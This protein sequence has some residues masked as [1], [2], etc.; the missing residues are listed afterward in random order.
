MVESMESSE[1]E[2]VERLLRSFGDEHA[3][4]LKTG[5]AQ[6]RRVWTEADGDQAAF[7]AFVREYFITDEKLLAETLQ[8][9]DR[10][11]EAISGHRVA[12]GRTLREPVDLSMGGL[13]P[14]DSMFFAFDPFDHAMED[15]FA[16][17]WAFVAL[18]NFEQLSVEQLEAAQRS[19]ETW[20]ASRLAS[21]FALRV[22][23]EV[24]RRATAAYAAAEEYIASYNIHLDQIWLAD[25]QVFPQGKALISHW[26]LRDELKAHYSSGAEAVE[27]Q[28]II[29]EIMLRII[30]QEIPAEVIDSAEHRWDPL[31][32]L[33]DGRASNGPEE[34]LRYAR[35]LDVFHAE[36][37]ID[38]YSPAFPSL[39]SRRFEYEREI[40]MEEQRAILE[41]VVSSPVAIEVGKLIEARLGRPLQP[42]D[43][44]YAGFKGGKGRFAEEELS[45]KT[46]AL[47]PD[48]AAFENA[49]P[50]IFS[51]MGFSETSIELLSSHIAVDAARGSGH[52]MGAGMRGDRA[53]L[54]TRVAADGMDY[55]GYNIAMHELGHNVE[56][57]FSLERLDWF[58]LSGVP[59][60][61]FTEAFAFVFQA[62]DLDVLGI[63]QPEASE[64]EREQAMEHLAM[65]W[66]TYEIA[67]VALL[68][69]AVW[70]YMYAHPEL[71][72]SQLREATI[73]LATQLW[74]R[75]Y[76]PVFGVSDS[77]ILAIYSHMIAYGLYLP[78][79]PLGHII[80]HQLEDYLLGKSLAEEMER[81]CRQGR[82]TP[83][84]WMQGAV[85]APLSAEPL[86]R[87]S[88]AALQT[89][90]STELAR[91]KTA[92]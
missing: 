36:Q 75:Y 85:G 83:N 39:M 44:W 4:R 90:A 22:P 60:T 47:Y 89:L 56:Q 11:L 25:Q 74:N 67:G 37:E 79:Y 49:L 23:G 30:R 62:R 26:G 32:N 54:R 80:Q 15:A 52:A 51:R 34:D 21:A 61:A 53:H 6:V 59:N 57:V 77:P 42:F 38:K 10:N 73:A 81:M 72:P 3:E 8:R 69:I 58:L 29:Y 24:K 13:L 48:A 86:L 82:L 92:Q 5:I 55:K 41:S 76:A 16:S 17:K 50:A 12:L 35:L 14:I 70:E 2:M 88:E 63:A 66:S 27:S 1:T 84:A 64:V 19:R 46:R 28:R 43:I 71:T 18:L 40:P 78:D 65:F 91:S 45:A 31:Q 9:F 20:A 68:D 87:A 33:V 7:E